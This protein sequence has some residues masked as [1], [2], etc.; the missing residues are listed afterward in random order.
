MS[1]GY[2]TAASGSEFATRADLH[3]ALDRVASAIALR[4]YLGVGFLA[5]VSI[6]VE[7]VA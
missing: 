1:P 7:M 4:L 6:A 5:L 3:E 2:T